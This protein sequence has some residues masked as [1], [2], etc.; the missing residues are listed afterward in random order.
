MIFSLKKKEIERESRFYLGGKLRGWVC[1]KYFKRI[2]RLLV[3]N[4]IEKLSELK[5]IFR[6]CFIEVIDYFF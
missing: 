5:N 1:Y 4:V 3:K 2:K 6:F